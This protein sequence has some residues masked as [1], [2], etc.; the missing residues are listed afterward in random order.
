MPSQ[1]KIARVAAF[2]LALC[3]CAAYEIDRQ[4]SVDAS[5]TGSPAASMDYLVYY[6]PGYDEPGDSARR[7][8]A[9]FMLHGFWEGGE[10]LHLLPKYGPSQQIEQG[11]DFPF[12]VVTPQISGPNWPVERTLAFIE[13]CIGQYRI[14]TERVYLTG[15]SIGGRATWAIAAARP[16]LF[17]AIA[18][19][20][21]WG[22]KEEARAAA[23]V[24]VWGFHGAEDPLISVSA[25]EAMHAAHEAA[26]GESELTIYADG[27]HTIYDRV[28]PGQFLYDWFLE[29]GGR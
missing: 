4:E 28:Y 5:K 13:Y 7:W 25:A 6:P 16:D 20:S 24:P 19:V 10:N 22:E 2:V 23:E 29:H 17:A 18:P 1:I 14:D 26:G 3:A 12:I 21:G 15:V 9:V 8:P 11:R 27:G